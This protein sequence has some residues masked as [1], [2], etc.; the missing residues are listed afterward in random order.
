MLQ[1]D[2]SLN[3]ISHVILDEVHERDINNDYLMI[4]VRDLL[5]KRPK[6]KVILMSATM[7]Q[8]LFSKYFGNCPILEVPI[9][10]PI[11]LSYFLLFI[12]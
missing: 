5:L 6:L 8:S 4:V 9:L 10:S 2:P 7:N 3:N 11:F 1:S 12:P